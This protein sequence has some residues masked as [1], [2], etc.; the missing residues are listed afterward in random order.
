MKA[1]ASFSA[2]VLF[3][4]GLGI[5][6]MT[7]PSKVTGFLDLFGA[8]DPSLAL[9]MVG[10]VAVHF[11]LYRVITRHATPLF[12]TRFHLPTRKDLDAR[13]VVGSSLFGIGWALGGYCPGPGL[14][15][16]ASG[17]L[18]AVVFVLSMAA[19]MKLEQLLGARRPLGDGYLRSMSTGSDD[20]R[21]TLPAA[22]HASARSDA[23]Y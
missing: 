19:G 7:Q 15:S 8:W 1:L 23:D 17:L 16:A 18:P 6:G 2:G 13:L 21:A 11:V 12:D 4:I 5:S 20:I 14:V 9:V 3:A 10:A 22:R